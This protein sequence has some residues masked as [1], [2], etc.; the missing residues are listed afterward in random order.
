MNENAS[1]D[2]I[3]TPSWI[4]CLSAN[5]SSSRGLN[6]EYWIKHRFWIIAGFCPSSSYDTGH[7]FCLDLCSRRIYFAI[8]V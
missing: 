5:E 2:E 1:E 8:I 4:K 6:I 3:L 7:D